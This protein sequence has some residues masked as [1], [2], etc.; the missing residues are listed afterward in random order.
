M[1]QRF[2]GGWAERNK[3][4]PPVSVEA[5][6]WRLGQCA[7]HRLPVSPSPGLPTFQHILQST[8]EVILATA[9]PL[10]KSVPATS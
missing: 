5:C 9:R 2:A 8:T 10:Q 4:Q 3:V 7:S 1:E 6:Q